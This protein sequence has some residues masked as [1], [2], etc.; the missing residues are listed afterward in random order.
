MKEVGTLYRTNRCV[1]EVRPENGRKFT[2]QELQAYVGGN[3]ELVPGTAR[4]GSPMAFCNEEGLLLK[5]KSNVNASI[6]FKV[7]LVGDVIQVRKEK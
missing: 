1:L 7:G 5:L 6:V 2:L 3:I 4:R